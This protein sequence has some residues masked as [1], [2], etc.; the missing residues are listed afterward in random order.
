[1]VGG[2]PKRPA[3]KVAGFKPPLPPTVDAASV[4]FDE[5]GRM[6]IKEP[7]K[8]AVVRP[9]AS[10]A[11]PPPRPGGFPASKGAPP[12]RPVGMVARRETTPPPRPAPPR[13]VRQPQASRPLAI[14]DGKPYDL[15]PE[16]IPY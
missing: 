9:P 12:P 13:P 4:E 8:P 11:A 15:R 10:I 6:V 1:M 14:R 2:F 16:D 3:P 5:D 7:L